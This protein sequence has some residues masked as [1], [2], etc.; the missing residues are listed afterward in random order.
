[1][2]KPRMV[3]G[4]R[5]GRLTA[6]RRLSPVGE[7]NIRWLFLCDC[8]IRFD[9]CAKNVTSGRTSSCGCYQ[10]ECAREHIKKLRE[11]SGYN[12]KKKKEQ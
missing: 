6:I 5:K 8:G 2:K 12:R 10:K 9:T 1:M 4:F 11:V 7:E 3:E